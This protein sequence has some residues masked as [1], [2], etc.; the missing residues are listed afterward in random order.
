MALRE[1]TSHG[2]TPRAAKVVWGSVGAKI[3][4][5][6]AGTWPDSVKVLGRLRAVR[7]GTAS[8]GTKGSSS[9][10]SSSIGESFLRFREPWESRDSDSDPDSD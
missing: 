3:F 1:P 6:L 4:P 9:S 5:L 10:S 7:E 2:L 8:L